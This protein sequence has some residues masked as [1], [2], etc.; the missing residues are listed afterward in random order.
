[1]ATAAQIDANRRNAARSTGPKSPAGKDRSRR[2]ALTHGL[3]AEALLPEDIEAQARERLERWRAHFRP[4]DPVTA[5]LVDRAARAAIK[6][7]RCA[8][9]DDARTADRVRRARADFDRA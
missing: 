1:M 6:L 9:A 2:N 8:R 4:D 5:A 7:D 3:T